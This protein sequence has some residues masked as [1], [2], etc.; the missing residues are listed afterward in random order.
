MMGIRKKKEIILT[1]WIKSLIE[2]MTLTYEIVC[3]SVLHPACQRAELHHHGMV[4]NFTD[5]ISFKLNTGN[6]TMRCSNVQ[7]SA[8]PRDIVLAKHLAE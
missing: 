8:A 1:R 4:P 7:H 3:V 5:L 2:T 6:F